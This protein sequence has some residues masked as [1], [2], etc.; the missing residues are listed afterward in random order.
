MPGLPVAGGS[1]P[2]AR[3]AGGRAALR[4][5]HLQRPVLTGHVI[6]VLFGHGARGAKAGSD[7]GRW[8]DDCRFHQDAVPAVLLYSLAPAS[9]EWAPVVRR[10]EM[11][12]AS[13]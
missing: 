10:S 9:L 8:V 3:G 1:P 13:R 2:L 5:G 7:L 4:A 6:H 12:R 11:P